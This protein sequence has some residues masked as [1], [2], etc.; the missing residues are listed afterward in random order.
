MIIPNL[1]QGC[2]SV[3]EPRV[4]VQKK[5]K[6]AFL[7]L[8]YLL[9]SRWTELREPSVKLYSNLLSTLWVSVFRMKTVIQHFSGSSFQIFLMTSRA[10]E[11]LLKGI[12]NLWNAVLNADG[13]DSRPWFLKLQYDQ[14]FNGKTKRKLAIFC[15]LMMKGFQLLIY[16]I[17]L[18]G[19]S[20]WN[21][22]ALKKKWGQGFFSRWKTRSWKPS[23]TSRFSQNGDVNG[24]DED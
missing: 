10:A 23:V 1:I 15:K 7:L 11:I 8:N 9:A 3:A 14:L 19:I 20:W 2:H 18:C 21:L 6:L 5:K 16:F 17:L 24:S 13:K 12:A 4:Q 22:F